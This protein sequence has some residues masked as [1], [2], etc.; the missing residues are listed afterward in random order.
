MH[1][2]A[3]T[4]DLAQHEEVKAFDL[5]TCPGR[6]TQKLQAG[7]Y[8]GLALKAAYRNTLTQRIPAVMR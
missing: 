3:A 6:F 2:R 8:A 4:F 7:R 1:R 5:V